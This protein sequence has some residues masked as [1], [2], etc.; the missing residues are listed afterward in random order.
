MFKNGIPENDISVCSV[1]R[2][3]GIYNNII[4]TRADN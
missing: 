4:K 3:K 2:V 1:E